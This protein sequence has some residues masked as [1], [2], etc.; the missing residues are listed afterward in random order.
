MLHL[1]RKTTTIAVRTG[2]AFS[3]V[4]LFTTFLPPFAW[5]EN[6]PEERSSTL[7][8]QTNARLIN[9]EQTTESDGEDPSSKPLP[10]GEIAK[11]T[12]GG[13]VIFI[14][15]LP[16]LPIIDK[17]GWYCGDN[18]ESLRL[19]RA[20]ADDP[21]NWTEYALLKWDSNSNYYYA[22][23]PLSEN[24]FNRNIFIPPPY[25]N[26][27]CT[28]VCNEPMNAY[29]NFFLRVTAVTTSE[30]VKEEETYG[31]V[32]FIFLDSMKPAPD[33][34]PTTKPS[35]PDDGSSG[36]NRGNVSP[37]ESERV[38]PSSTPAD[39]LPDV[40]KAQAAESGTSTS[41]VTPD[42]EHEP[43]DEEKALG[44]MPLSS[45]SEVS[46]KVDTKTLNEDPTEPANRIPG[47]LQAIGAT[48][49]VATATIMVLAFRKPLAKRL[50]KLLS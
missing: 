23:D 4:A 43:T 28:V 16:M 11:V 30:E 2:C 20:Y 3:L 1:T 24:G 18:L 33:D 26:N 29:R 37:G 14:L 40:E 46:L 50:S 42:V 21:S 5:A 17:D 44:V 10:R 9:G 22:I 13:T 45:G 41:A 19:E 47:F 12:P 39:L 35:D 49:M 32:S 7:L 8:E 34:K 25:Y 38:D 31:P 6:T 27:F 15:Y 36:G 48:M